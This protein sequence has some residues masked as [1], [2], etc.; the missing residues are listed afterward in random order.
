MPRPYKKGLRSTVY[1]RNKVETA[2]AVVDAERLLTLLMDNAL[3]KIELDAIRQRSIEIALRKSLP[4]LSATELSID[5]AQP[6]AVLPATV[7]DSDQW[8]EQFAPKT[9]H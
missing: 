1:N 2:R 3:G 9:E 7:E 6:F 5:H 4:D 8:Q